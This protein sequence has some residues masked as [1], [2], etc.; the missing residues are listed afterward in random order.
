MFNYVRL[1]DGGINRLD[2]VKSEVDILTALGKRLLPNSPVDFT[3][4][5]NHNTVREAIANILPELAELK[6]ISAAK[7]EF[8]VRG[9]LKHTPEFNRP[10]GLAYMPAGTTNMA[11]ATKDFPFLLATVRSEG[12]FNTIIY[13][14]TDSYRYNA[15]RDSVLMNP[16]DVKK[17]GLNEFD[18]VI[19]ISAHGSMPNTTV[20]LLDLP[21]GNL[22]AYFPEA[23]VLTEHKLDPRSRTP[24]FKSVAVKIEKLLQGHSL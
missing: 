23:N 14:E 4:F 7:H 13:E 17:L 19:L 20:R 15:P 16:D 12:Q 5:K 11:T 1:S 18:K 2:N 10:N 22:L 21:P 9:R 8:H 3:A 6:D 24:N